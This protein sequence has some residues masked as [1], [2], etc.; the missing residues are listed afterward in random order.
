[1]MPPKP[2]EGMR[3]SSAN[4]TIIIVVVVII[5][6]LVMTFLHIMI[7]TSPLSPHPELMLL[8]GFNPSAKTDPKPVNRSKE[9]TDR[10]T[11]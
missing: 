4:V 9:K 7:L 5:T 10:Q 8:G 1:M 3:W 11:N 2:T 6:T